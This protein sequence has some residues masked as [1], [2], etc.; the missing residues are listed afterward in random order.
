M[1]GIQ[2]LEGLSQLLNHDTSPDESIKGDAN[3][4]TRIGLSATD[5]E[6]RWS[7]GRG[8]HWSSFKHIIFLLD[9]TE[10]LG[11]QIVSE[12][13]EGILELHTI[14]RTGAIFVEVDVDSFPLLDVFPESGKF[15]ESDSSAAIGIEYGH[16]ELAS[17]NIK[18]S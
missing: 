3:F 8:H 5:T 2:P 16:Q 1:V 9:K 10:E 7:R 11:G 17:V 14:D 15:I 13:F 6:S 4:L 18:G 12:L